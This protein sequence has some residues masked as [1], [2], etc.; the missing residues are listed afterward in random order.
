MGRHNTCSYEPC[1]CLSKLNKTELQIIIAGKRQVFHNFYY[2][3]RV[4]C[5]ERVRLHRTRSKALY[6]GKVDVDATF[7]FLL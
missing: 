3:A 1:G 6:A 7:C 4:F 2:R 5:I